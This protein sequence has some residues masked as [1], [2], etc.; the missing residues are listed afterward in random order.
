MLYGFLSFYQGVSYYWLGQHGVE[1]RAFWLLFTAPWITSLAVFLIIKFDVKNHD[2]RPQYLPNCQ[3]L[4]PLAIIP[5]SIAFALDF[6]VE[7]DPVAIALTWVFIFIAFAMQT[8][9][10]F[11]LVELVIPSEVSKGT[12]SKRIGEAWWPSDW[13]VPAAFQHILYF[14]CPPDKLQPGQ[15]DIVRE[16]KDGAYLAVQKQNGKPVNFHSPHD[17][18][19][20][21]TATLEML[22]HMWEHL[23][24]D[25]QNHVKRLSDA[26]ENAGKKPKDV[27]VREAKDIAMEL[28]KIRTHLDFHE[29][30][31]TDSDGYGSEAS[32]A[33]NAS[34]KYSAKAGKSRMRDQEK[35]YHPEEP[36]FMRYSY[37]EPWALL[38][39]VTTTLAFSWVFLTIGMF[40]DVFVGVQG[41]ITAPHWAR[42]PM[43]RVSLIPFE[44]GTP[45]GR[46]QHGSGTEVWIPEEMWWAEN[47]APKPNGWHPHWWQN[48]GHGENTRRLSSP[49][50]TT[51][52]NFARTHSAYT[53]GFNHALGNFFGALDGFS[54]ASAVAKE[55][56]AH[57]VQWPGFFEP[58]LLACEPSHDDREPVVAAISTRGRAVIVSQTQGASSMDTFSLTGLAEFPQ[59]LGASWS[60]DGLIMVSHAGDV[61]SCPGRRPLAGGQWA[62]GHLN[63]VPSR[64]PTAEEGQLL[65]ATA[66]W[67]TTSEGTS[68]LHAALVSKSAP[69]VVVMWRLD[70]N[71]WELL[72]E[73][74]MPRTKETSIYVKPTLSF[75]GDSDIV[76]VT[77]SNEIIRRR[78]TDGSMVKSELQFDKSPLTMQ[79]EESASIK[80]QG[81]CGL[82]SNG[83]LAH[84]SLRESSSTHTLRPQLM[85][86]R[87]S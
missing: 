13:Q 80:W 52:Y 60:K 23:T 77:S 72:G 67:M 58:R 21:V 27:F 10:S 32:Y 16:V 46:E 42:P 45:L 70:D 33:S 5:A 53:T 31:G 76:V 9:Y 86:T 39:I 65:T 14:V 75:A 74:R 18:E 57:S 4:G 50:A 82:H 22:F 40:I 28:D 61:L 66:S 3:Y 19:T 37:A 12:D 44:R 38:C 56:H 24:P 73:L 43:T 84:L 71:S 85:M 26:F 17:L 68:R 47:L 54:S 7:Y 81:V 25:M 83:A 64:V 34:S 55:W 87:Q 29:Q 35:A 2:N 11:R 59:L 30:S 69:D 41:L 63:G 48:Y 78:V 49:F 79:T 8:L 51:R 1:L 15:N 62:C 36:D 20:V 6:R